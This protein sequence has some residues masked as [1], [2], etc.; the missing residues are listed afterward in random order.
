[1]SDARIVAVGVEEEFHILDLTTRQLVPR[2]EEVLRRLDGDSFSPELL[3]S[4][5]ETNSQP[6]A[7]LLE[8][9]T[10]L[11]DLR[12]RLAE[13]TGELGLGPAA[14]GTVPIVD[15]DLLDVSRDDRYE[16][17]TEDYQIVAREQLI[18][19]AQVHVDVADRDLAMA[20]VAWTA[21]W[22]PMLLALSA[23]SPF[24]MGADSGYASMRT[25]VWQRWPTAGVAGSFRTAAEYDQLVADLIKSGVISDPGM[26]YFDVRPSAHLPTVE[27]RICDACPDVDNVILI[28]GLFRALVCQAIEEIEAGGQAPPPR[29]EL[30]RAATWRAARSGLEGD[31]VDIL[32]AG[33]IPAQAMLRRLLTEVRPQLERFD[34]WELIDNLAEQAVGRG[35]SAH[36]QR[37]AFAR[38]GLLTDVADLVLAETRDVPPAGAAA[39]LGS[40]PA[41]SASDQIA[42]RLLERYQPTGYDEI[43]D[44]RGAVRP[45]YRAVMRTLERLGPGILDERVGTREAEQNDRGIVFRASGDS[46]SRPFPFDLVPRIIAADDWTTLT[47]GLSQRVRALEAFLHDIY[48]ERAAVADG[49]VPA[50]VVND[51]PSLRHG[52]RAVG[53]DAIRVT[54]AGIDLV[55]GGDGGWL[56]LEDNLRVPSGIA[57]AMEGRRLAES[58]LPELGP[59][60]G[61]L[62]LDGIP[63]LL[64]EAL[65]AAAPAAATGDP[66]VAVLTGGK[67]DAAYFEHSL[68]AE[69]M[70]VALVEPAD[71][72]VDDNDVVYRIDGSRR[73]RVDV[74]YRRMDEDDLFGALGAAGTPLGLPL[75]RAIR[76]RRVGI[77]NALG[78]GVGDDKVV[79]AYVPRMVT[80]YLGEQPVLDDV[81]TYVCGDPEQC[82][83][84][85]DNLDQLVVKPVD[86]YGGSGVVIGP[87]AEPYRLTEVRERILANPRQWIGQELVS[88]STHPTWHDSHLEPCA[89]DLRVFVYAGREP[90][91]VPAALSRVAPPGSLIV[92]SSQGGGSKDTW[93]PRR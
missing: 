61:I 18:C 26:V 4:V 25:L 20:V 68:L 21:P 84:V 34:D 11:L 52:G 14:A 83:H 16:Q 93:I 27:L 65:V 76:A 39:A 32:G 75:L 33:P 36:R 81:P 86:G 41:V 1:M 67:T 2:A 80:Y 59:P 49:I 71:L 89:V 77:A 63:A 66:A 53:P 3:K 24:W 85:L 15:M 8:L 6:T 17:M 19:G 70:G 10:N 79:Y 46:A 54:V 91:V 88:L 31:L 60:A 44:A 73:C 50:W 37:R 29:A 22:L 40:A 90:R 62:R 13:V 69:K 47:T 82:E 51:A 58:V 87:H 38:R 57:Y 78:N 56:V 23:S 64:H 45:Q 28:A 35:S 55:R 5:V 42:P 72:L 74:L 43:V 12:R 48:G 92:N 30:L 7:D 9:R